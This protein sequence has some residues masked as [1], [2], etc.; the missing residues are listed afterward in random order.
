MARTAYMQHGHATAVSAVTKDGFGSSNTDVD[1]ATTATTEIDLQSNLHTGVAA[2]DVGDDGTLLAAQPPPHVT[3]HAASHTNGC[4]QHVSTCA[5]AFGSKKALILIVVLAVV[6]VIASI[7]VAVNPAETSSISTTP[8]PSKSGGIDTTADKCNS[9]STGATASP[10]CITINGTT[11]AKTTAPIATAPTASAATGTDV[12][13]QYTPTTAVAATTITTAGNGGE[14]VLEEIVL[15]ND[16]AALQE[17][18]VAK[19]TGVSAVELPDGS[20]Q[21]IRERST[22]ANR[23]LAAGFLQTALR[24][25]GLEPAVQRYSARGLNVYAWLNATTVASTSEGDYGSEDESTNTV[26]THARKHRARTVTHPHP[27]ARTNARTHACTHPPTNMY[28][29]VI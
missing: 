21:F 20:M 17:L 6:G 13:E 23:A 29:D 18:V 12:T 28:V 3:V 14:A 22:A 8:R 1:F 5:T 26:R 15:S 27:H 25:L 10:S 4:Q 11:R 2:G 16:L 7:I 9:N 24:A 19:L